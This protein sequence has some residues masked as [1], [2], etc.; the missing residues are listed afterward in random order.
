MK[1][2][3]LLLALLLMGSAAPATAGD[4]EP[5][6]AAAVPKQFY[7]TIRER[8]IAKGDTTVRVS[9]GDLVELVFATDEAGRLHL[10]GYDIEFDV[11]PHDQ[12]RVTFEAHATGRFPVT[13]H[14]FGGTHDHGHQALLYVEVYPD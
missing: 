11:S 5:D 4:A 10:H 13:S 2:A 14:G 12:V 9:Q 7:L 1:I 3:G 8:Q 6:E